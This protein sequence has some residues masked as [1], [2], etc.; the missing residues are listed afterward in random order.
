MIL[1]LFCVLNVHFL[2]ICTQSFAGFGLSQVVTGHAHISTTGHTFLID[3]ALVTSFHTVQEC[4]VIPPLANSDHFG[5]HIALGLR[6]TVGSG[7]HQPCA[8]TIWH[9]SYANFTPAN[10]IDKLG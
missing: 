3:F 8:R 10:K 9:Y 5:I 2:T 7:R 4:V 1:I 6:S